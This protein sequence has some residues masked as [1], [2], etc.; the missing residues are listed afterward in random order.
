MNA[1]M[2]WQYNLLHLLV[3]NQCVVLFVWTLD[4]CPFLVLEVSLSG[5]LPGGSGNM[6]GSFTIG[7]MVQGY[8]IT[9]CFCYIVVAL[10]TDYFH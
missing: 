9:H 1:V 4:A 3:L 8:C 5:F 7:T 10:E 2:L 6:I